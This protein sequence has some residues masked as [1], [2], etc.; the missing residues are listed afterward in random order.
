MYGKTGVS[1]LGLG[2]FRGEIG[3]RHLGSGNFVTLNV[4]KKQ[5]SKHKFVRMFR[6]PQPDAPETFESPTPQTLNPKPK[7]P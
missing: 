4:R 3:V 6:H 1:S 5:E 7:K 2:G